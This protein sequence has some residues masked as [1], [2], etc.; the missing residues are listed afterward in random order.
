MYCKKC[1]EKI[2]GAMNFCPKC[3]TKIENS[4]FL[5]MNN[6]EV[7]NTC[8]NKPDSEEDKTRLEKNRNQGKSRMNLWGWGMSFFS[9]FFAVLL[10]STSVLG[11]ICV[12]ISAILFCPIMWKK[13]NRKIISIVCGIAIYI[14]GFGLIL[15]SDTSGANTKMETVSNA[16]EMD[17]K[18]GIM[19]SK[20]TWYRKYSS[21]YNEE[22]G[23][24]LSVYC[25]DNI[26]FGVDYQGEN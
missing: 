8:E 17:S 4:S 15:G 6:H 9:I 11:S 22:T 25:E 18:D 20:N 10:F 26:Q 5:E 16:D 3:G 19:D 13:T 23:N 24:K 7:V 21:F 14:I 12:I 2:E 1:G